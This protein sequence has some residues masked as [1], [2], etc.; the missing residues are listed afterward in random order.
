MKNKNVFI[1][2]ILVIALSI[3]FWVLGKFIDFTKVIP[4]Q[5]PISA[6]M[7]FCPAFAAIILT[8]NDKGNTGRLLKRAF[9]FKRI[10]NPLWYIP[11][12]FLIPALMCLTFFV[13]QLLQVSLPEFELKT[14]DLIILAV[15][16][17]FG[18][19]SEEI[20]WTAYLT[21]RLEK[22]IGLL[23]IALIIG[24]FWAIWHIIPFYQAHRTTSWI[25]WHCAGTVALR[26]IL[27]WIYAN[28]GKSLFAVVICHT[29]VNLSEFCFPN[30]GSHY[31][32]FY[33]GIVLILTATIISIWGLRNQ[34]VHKQNELSEE[35]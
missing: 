15:L 23:T 20:G 1:F 21:V 11:T 6:L 7:I 34:S 32:P 31:D 18:A 22:K 13:M 27:V 16:F 33:F 3:P 30:Y 5:L 19:L 26:V 17:F 2:F 10:S 35:K 29:T 9:D 14:T 12:V 4:I 25:F 24:T 28:T 8:R